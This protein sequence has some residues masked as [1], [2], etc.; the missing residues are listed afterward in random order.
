MNTDD[1][2]RRLLNAG[3]MEL[4]QVDAVLEGR[5][6]PQKAPADE[7]LLVSVGAAAKILGVSRTCCWRLRKSGHLPV[8]ELMPGC[9]RVRL[10]DLHRIA[11]GRPA[12]SGETIAPSN[13]GG[14]R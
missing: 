14:V 9:Y 11:A 5:V 6:Q 13:E 8:V 3:P 7:P 1:R 10:G 4:D 12:I 2:I